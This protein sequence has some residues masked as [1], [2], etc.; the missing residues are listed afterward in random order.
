M[1]DVM[2][3][4]ATAGGALVLG[5]TIVFAVSRRRRLSAAEKSR[6]GRRVNELYGETRR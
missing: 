4:L 1:M 2:W 6:Q 5:L 3:L